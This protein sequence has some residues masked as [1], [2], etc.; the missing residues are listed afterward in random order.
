MDPTADELAGVVELFG[1]LDRDE[2]ARALDELAARTG[3]QSL[4][5]EELTAS[6]ESALDAFVLVEHPVGGDAGYAAG[7]TAF[8][9]PPAHAEDLPHILDVP[10]RSPDTEAVG[11]RAADRFERAVEDAIAADDAERAREL[12]DLS[13][14]VEAWAPVTLDAERE[15]LDDYLE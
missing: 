8:P 4:P 12:L 6:V 11:E 5:D 1:A 9:D 15:R 3:A 10:H 7:P 13:Y 2:L 14:D